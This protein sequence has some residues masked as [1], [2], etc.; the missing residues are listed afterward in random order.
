MRLEDGEGGKRLRLGGP[1]VKGGHNGDGSHSQIRS[2]EGG[3]SSK[4]ADSEH[5]VFLCTQKH[6]AIQ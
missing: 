5:G 3:A 2:V 6:K 4:S 1:L